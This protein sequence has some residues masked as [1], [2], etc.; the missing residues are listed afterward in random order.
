VHHEWNNSKSSRELG[1][2]IPEL[3]NIITEIKS[4]QVDLI[5]EYR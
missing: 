1:T 4:H 3:K 2:K 5:G